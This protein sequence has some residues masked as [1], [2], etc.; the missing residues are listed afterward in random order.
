MLSYDIGMNHGQDTA[1]Y[2]AAGHNVVAVE[3]N[4]EL[5]AANE[6]QFPDAIAAGRL[7]IVNLGIAADAGELP[8]YLN[9]HN[10][11]WSSFLPEQGA[12]PLDGVVTAHEII[13]VKTVPFSV[14]LGLYGMPDHLKIDIEGH[15][16]FCLE[17]L[18]A[19]YRPTYLS[20]EAQHSMQPWLAKL[21][22]IG[23]TRF[24]FVRQNPYNG[25]SGPFGDAA[26]DVVSG[27][28]WR[29]AA[30]VQQSWDDSAQ[31]FS[32]WFDVHAAITPT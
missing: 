25:G 26:V 5:C 28:A 17:P 4:P 11:D 30:E 14:V 12:R 18:R 31:D 13:P 7:R 10:D 23:F 20:F 22:A 29:T 2:L 16:A 32:S 15:D 1:T 27:T 6:A 3:A 8:F 24:K 19:D 21:G 9:R